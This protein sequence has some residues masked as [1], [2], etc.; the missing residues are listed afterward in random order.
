MAKL[1]SRY[2]ALGALAVCLLFVPHY[3][4]AAEIHFAVIPNTTAGDTATIIEAR[5]DPPATR[6]QCS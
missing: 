5:I 3:I 2:L 1:F 6:P 4:Y